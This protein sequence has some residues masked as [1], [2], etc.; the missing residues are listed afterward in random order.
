MLVAKAALLMSGFI[1]AIAD[2][3]NLLL[4]TFCQTSEIAQLWWA[5]PPG[6]P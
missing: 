4:R 2:A 3:V 5:T 1:S 6:L